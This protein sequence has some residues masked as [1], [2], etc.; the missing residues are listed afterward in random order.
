MHILIQTCRIFALLAIHQFMLFPARTEIVSL[1]WFCRGIYPSAPLYRTHVA[2]VATMIYVIKSES[3]ITYHS[4]EKTPTQHG[5]PLIPRP[6]GANDVVT[7]ALFL[8]ELPRKGRCFLAHVTLPTKG[9]A[10]L[11]FFFPCKR[12]EFPTRSPVHI[13]YGV[14]HGS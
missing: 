7:L 14:R 12:P 5:L 8:A 3:R 6:N 2:K 11:H 1:G 9:V 13:M 10:C 4:T